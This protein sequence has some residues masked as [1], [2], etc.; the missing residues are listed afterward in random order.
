MLAREG[1]SMQTPPGMPSSYDAHASDSPFDAAA[2]RRDPLEAI[3]ALNVGT[4]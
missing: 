4:S 1:D 2:Q 3:Y